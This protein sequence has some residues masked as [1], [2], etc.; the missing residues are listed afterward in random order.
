VLVHLSAVSVRLSVALCTRNCAP[1]LRAQLES[2]RGQSLLPDEL[3]VGDEASTDGTWEILE[4]FAASAP[5][6]VRLIRNAQPLGVAG[7]FSQVIAACGGELIALCDHDDVWE[8]ERLAR[9]VAAMRGRGPVSEAAIPER[10]GSVAL[11]FSDA[12]LIDAAGAAIPG[13]L[14]ARMDLDA[15]GLASLPTQR[16][17]AALLARRAITGGTMTLRGDVARWALPIPLGW[18][19]DEWMAQLAVLRGGAVAIAE[20]LM[21][22]RQHAGNAVGAQRDGFAARF[23]L[24]RDGAH[25]ERLEAQRKQMLIL[26]E[27]L[28]AKTGVP[29]WAIAAVDARVAH[30]DG[31]LA[32]QGGPVRRTAALLREL[33]T[34]RYAG[35]ARGYWSALQDLLS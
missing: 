27:Q 31:R 22:Y 16:L 35:N 29:D 30:L 32:V 9:S 21:R 26:R 1:Y 5:F 19:Q 3:V 4:A 11:A 14:W 34:G 13:R 7:N 23:R 28:A 6:S 12:S 10:A 17:F 33:S 8:P 2:L 18:Y 25:R 24:A 20:P 15:V